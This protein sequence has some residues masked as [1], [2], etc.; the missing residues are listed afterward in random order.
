M[1]E[2]LKKEAIGISLNVCKILPAAL[3]DE[4]GDYAAL[5]IAETKG[6]SNYER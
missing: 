1:E 4:I 6:V 3:G 5:A 2:Y